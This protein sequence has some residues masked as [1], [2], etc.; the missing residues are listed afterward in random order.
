MKIVITDGLHEADYIISKYKNRNNN[1]VVVN[2]S[3]EA[4]RYL[5]SRNGIP[6]MLGKATREK[7]LREAGAENADL[8]IALSENDMENYVV[9]QTA[10][11]LLGAKRCVTVVIN[12]KNVEVFRRLG[13]DSVLSSTYLLGEQVRNAASIENMLN[14]LTLEDDRIVI[15][16]FKITP[17]LMVCG[18]TLRD[19]N[20]A[21]KGMISSVIR[22]SKTIIPNGNTCLETDDKILVVTTEDNRDEITDMMQ[23]KA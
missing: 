13:I 6:V 5:S 8:F 7:D 14:T 11:K 21:D 1:L 15:I 10:K 19:I 17:D 22:G 4:C 2:G 23:R 9:C 3:E 12:P 20:I 16:E 18:Q